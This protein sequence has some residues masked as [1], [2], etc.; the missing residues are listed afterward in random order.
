MQNGWY[1]PLSTKDD[2]AVH[3]NIFYW[4]AGFTCQRSDWLIT[5]ARH[6]KSDNLCSLECFMVCQRTKHFK[7][8]SEMINKLVL[9]IIHLQL[10]A[11][12][13]HTSNFKP[14]K[15]FPHTCFVTDKHFPK[16]KTVF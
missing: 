13:D 12:K 9:V 2:G 3:F 7:H 5:S 1:G 15:Y 10:V 14:N 8:S 4:F 6:Q 16:L 11:L